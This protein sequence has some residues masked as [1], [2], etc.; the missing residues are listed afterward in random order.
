MN[1]SITDACTAAGVMPHAI[2]S[3]H[4]RSYQRYTRRING[5]QVLYI[6]AGVAGCRL[7]QC[8]PPA[9]PPMRAARSRMTP[10]CRHWGICS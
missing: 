3:A 10:R 6:V 5:Q 2:F 9:S 1:Q 7:S 4:A 8:R